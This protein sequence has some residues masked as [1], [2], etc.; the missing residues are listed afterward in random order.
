M[1]YVIKLKLRVPERHWQYI[2]IYIFLSLLREK[3]TL[4]LLS[5]NYVLDAKT[6]YYQPT[7]RQLSLLVHAQKLAKLSEDQVMGNYPTIY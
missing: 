7:L 2:Y 6:N 1:K 5:S 4:Q 3:V